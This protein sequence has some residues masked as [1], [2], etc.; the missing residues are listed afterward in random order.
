MKLKKRLNSEINYW[1]NQANE[2]REK[3]K[4]NSDNAT[5]RADELSE[6]LNKRLDEIELERKIS[7]AAP[8]IVGGALII[9][10]GYFESEKIFSTDF[11][12]RSK[13]EK[14]TMESIMKIERELGNNPLDVS[15]EK[16]GYDIESETSNGQ[17]KF[18]EVKGR[19]FSADTVTIS[20]NEIIT[21]LNSPENFI[22][23]VVSVENNSANVIYLKNPFTRSPDFN[24]VSVNYKISSLK[25]QGQIILERN[26]IFGD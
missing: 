11:S 2:L 25:K 19:N 17:L 18:I 6:R 22:L 5:R 9:P 26:I 20:K 15:A 7:V 23:A 16:R 3:D 8:V 1:D 12:A 24:A 14:F 13:I 21:A 10:R 4:I